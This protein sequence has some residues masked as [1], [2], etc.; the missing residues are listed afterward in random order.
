VLN[1]RSV[2]VATVALALLG[3]LIVVPASPAIASGTGDPDHPCTV[4]PT[5]AAC[6]TWME[7]HGPVNDATSPVCTHHGAYVPC[8]SQ[9]AIQQ[10][11]GWW[12]GDVVVGRHGW[13][14]VL[15]NGEA[16]RIDDPAHGGDPL[17]GCWA[18]LD[19]RTGGDSGAASPGG[20]PDSPGA[21]YQIACLG[22]ETYRDDLIWES[23]PGFHDE[24]RAWRSTGP[25]PTGDPVR[26]AHNAHATLTITDPVPATAPPSA[27][28]SVPLGMPVWLAID[29]TAPNGWG[30]LHANGCDGPVCVEIETYVHRIEWHLGDGTVRTCPRDRN[31]VW[32][33]GL[34]FLQPADACHHVY[35]APSRDLDGGHYE[36]DIIAHW[37]THWRAPS[38]GLSS[39]DNP[40]THTYHATATI[41]VDEIQV[42]IR[43]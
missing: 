6:T 25:V 9:R 33:A 38:L 23:L 8:R 37:H 35:A 28:G 13:S 30:H 22:T 21:W 17:Y 18:W 14:F 20:N 12:V 4:A 39:G 26:A 11:V 31:R 42:L 34:D 32:H 5:S 24:I 1:H 7:E 19:Q 43:R 16:Y 15:R 41:R 10:R 36:I 40:L 27:T 29:D 2:T 3:G